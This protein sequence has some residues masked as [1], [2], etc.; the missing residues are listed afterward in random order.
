MTF[1]AH[2]RGTYEW[3]RDHHL[4]QD[5]NLITMD[6]E[7]SY[8]S[9]ADSRP[10]NVRGI[11]NLYPVNTRETLGKPRGFGWRDVGAISP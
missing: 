11:E 10:R 8:K 7:L 4:I 2:D 9:S 1:A 5:V 6:V 3:P